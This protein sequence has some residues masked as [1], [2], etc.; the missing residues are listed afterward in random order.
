MGSQKN[1]LNEAI[2]EPATIREA[3]GKRGQVSSKEV[4][5]TGTLGEK[6]ASFFG[7]TRRRGKVWKKSPRKE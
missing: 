5:N 3:E 2:K 7:K 1:V 6:K 4:G